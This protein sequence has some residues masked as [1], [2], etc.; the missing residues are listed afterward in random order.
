MSDERSLPFG[1]L[2]FFVNVA[3]VVLCGGPKKLSHTSSIVQYIFYFCS[4]EISRNI[5]RNLKYYIWLDP[6]ILTVLVIWPL[7]R[8]MSV[9][10]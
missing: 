8:L 2:V 5:L 1:L 3:G 10:V 4:F 7:F 6:Y 9:N